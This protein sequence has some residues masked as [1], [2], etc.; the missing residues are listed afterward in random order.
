MDSAV[1]KNRLDEV[2]KRID[3]ACTKVDR[4]PEEVQL[5]PVSKTHSS[6]VIR[7]AHQIGLSRF[8]ENKVQEALLKSEETKDLPLRWCIIGHL[9]TNKVKD[10]VRFA[11]ELHSLDRMKLALELEKHLQKQG[12]SLDVLLQVNTSDEPQKYGLPPE[13]V[14]SFAQ[15][16]KAF[17]SL[18]VK[19]LMTLAIFSD[20]KELV[21]SCFKRLKNLQIKLQQEASSL[22][23]W[24]TLSMGMSG[25]LEIAIEEGSTEVRVGQS[26]FGKRSIPDSHYWPGK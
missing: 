8:G 1:L 10:V 5:L 3:L 17:S 11:S 20:N 23:T 9:Q 4:S 14:L 24:Q 6:E 16:L 21:R 15:E 22:S 19:G 7:Q 26:I 13:E 2:R 12:R 25:D 18:K